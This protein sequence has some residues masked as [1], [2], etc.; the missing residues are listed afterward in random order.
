[1]KYGRFLITKSTGRL[2]SSSTLA[3]RLFFLFIGFS[4]FTFVRGQSEEDCD[5][6]C[7]KLCMYYDGDEKSRCINAN[8]FCSCGLPLESI[9]LLILLSFTV[10]LIVVGFCVRKCAAKRRAAVVRTV[11]DP[12]STTE[13][14]SELY[15][16]VYTIEDLHSRHP[17]QLVD[18]PPSYIEAIE[19]TQPADL[20]NF[21]YYNKSRSENLNPT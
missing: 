2:N 7:H 9:I 12:D 15:P 20:E 3:L 21:N 16:P 4:E 1:M 8:A 10:L 13:A 19:M 5:L 14:R 11:P 18:L 6:Y 17:G